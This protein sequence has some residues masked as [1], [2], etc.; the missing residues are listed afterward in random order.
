M[1][2]VNDHTM[3]NAKLIAA[4][5]QLLEALKNARRFIVV[6]DPEMIGYVDGL[7]ARVEGR[8]DR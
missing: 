2:G 8:E 4:A 3:P 6:N 1:V 7:I 5:P